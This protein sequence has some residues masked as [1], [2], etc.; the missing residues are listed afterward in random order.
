[1]T[2]REVINELR[3]RWRVKAEP[4]V[5]MSTHK[6]MLVEQLGGSALYDAL[7]WDRA[8]ARW[9]VRPNDAV[10]YALNNPSHRR[11]A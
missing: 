7:T 5:P 4:T 6:F 8:N 2:L 9:D 3:R 1:M 10:N 11:E